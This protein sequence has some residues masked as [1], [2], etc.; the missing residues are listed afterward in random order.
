MH[1]ASLGFV[2]AEKKKKKKRT[3]GRSRE[4]FSEIGK[5][6]GEPNGYE[7]K[8]RFRRAKL[9]PRTSLFKRFSLPLARASGETNEG[10]ERKR[11]KTCVNEEEGTGKASREKT[12]ITGTIY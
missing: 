6:S 2:I 5:T 1:S 10:G 7:N 3:G 4:R 12:A 9:V 11:R 8:T